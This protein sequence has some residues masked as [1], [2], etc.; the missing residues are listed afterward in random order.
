MPRFS[1]QS[2]ILKV[3]RIIFWNAKFDFST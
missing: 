1:T 3:R 2:M